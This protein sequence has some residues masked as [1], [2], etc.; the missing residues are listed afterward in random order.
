MNNGSLNKK[1]LVIRLV[2]LALLAATGSLLFYLGKEHIILLDNKAAEIGGTRYEA[3]KYVRVTINGDR[4]KTMELNSGER[5]IVKISGPSHYI[6]AEIIDRQT[7]TIV[8]SAERN[9]NFG[10]RSSFMISIPALAANAPDVYLP[11]PGSI[12]QAPSP[13]PDAPASDTQAVPDAGAEIEPP[14]L[15]D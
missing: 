14:A 1:R 4:K 6:K 2:L 12:A 7:D 8:S 13:V 15:S 11:L 3:A 9:F 5:V 10:K